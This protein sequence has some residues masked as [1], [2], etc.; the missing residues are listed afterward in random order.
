MTTI[1]K[2]E[3]ELDLDSGQFTGKMTQAGQVV[4]V[5][6]K[7]VNQV[8]QSVHRAEQRITGLT[9]RVR[10]LFVILGQA[11]AAMHTLWSVTGSWAS[12]I[13]KAAAELE[14]LQKL[15]EG[16]SRSTDATQRR[17]EGMA[18]LKFNLDLAKN[19]P[20]EVEQ[21]TNAFVK[22]KSAGIDPTAG[23]LQGL[24]DAVAHFGGNGQVLNRASVAIQQMA[25]KGVI[26]MEELRQQLGEAIP[27]AMEMMARGAGVSVAELVK[28]ISTGRVEAKS[29]LAIMFREFD[30]EFKGS[31]KGMMNTWQGLIAQLRTEFMVFSKE[32]GDAG[33]MDALKG[34]V[35][36]LIALTKDPQF[37]H[38]AVD[39]GKGL[40]GAVTGI[41]DLV[42]WAVK[43]RNELELIAAAWIGI[44]LGQFANTALQGLG[45]VLMQLGSLRANLASTVAAMGAAR[46]AS[47][48]MAAAIGAAAGPI[49][50]AITA[51]T[52]LGAVIWDMKQQTEA[53][54]KT[55]RDFLDD[56]AKGSAGSFE[57]LTELQSRSAKLQE[58]YAAY[59][60][61]DRSTV[62]HRRDD[63]NSFI[64]NELGLEF[65]EKDIKGSVEKAQKVVSDAMR[66]WREN[67]MRSNLKVGTEA[68]T[69]QLSAAGE[70]ALRTLRGQMV[71]FQRQLTEA[72]GSKTAGG[73]KVLAARADAI[74]AAYA[75]VVD[76][77]K[78]IETAE[79]AA[80]DRNKAR[81]GDIAKEYEERWVKAKEAVQKAIETRDQLLADQ[82]GLKL[83]NLPNQ[84]DKQ[85]ADQA[86]N[87]LA[88]LKGNVAELQAKLAGTN[89]EMDEF[90]A[91]LAGGATAL[92][93]LKP[94]Q[95]KEAEQLLKTY[96]D[97]KEQLKEQ[98]KAKE[99]A[100]QAD[101]FLSQKKEALLSDLQAEKDLLA[102]GGYEMA[103]NGLVRLNR[104]LARQAEALRAA[105][106]DMDA[107]NKEADELR[108]IQSSIDLSRFEQETRQLRNQLQLDMAPNEHARNQI[109]LEREIAQIR[110]RVQAEIDA[111]ADRVQAEALALDRIQA[112][113]DQFHYHDRSA[114]QRMLDDWKDATD[115]LES[116]SANVF[117]S[118]SGSIA[119]LVV[120]GKANFKDLSKM[121]IKELIKIAI[122]AMITRIAMS[123]MGGSTAPT[124]NVSGMAYTGANAAFAKGGV[125][126]SGGP[127]PLRAYANGGIAK[128]P[129]LAL[130]GEGSR[131]EAYVPLPDG[132]SIPVTMSGASQN[133][134]V[135]IINETGNKVEGEQKGSRFDGST[136]ILDVVLKAVNKPGSFRDGMK[137]ALTR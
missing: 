41:I 1:S 71:D 102:S 34:G 113:R 83:L 72:G 120:D 100:A 8:A 48:G 4:Q 89:S 5:F 22:L 36:E 80:F 14:R 79:Q 60:R 77:L 97:L 31:S 25:G 15:M 39:L 13:V 86:T 29:A 66:K 96:H 38:F 18:S 65:D 40:G 20:F 46:V 127:M 131:P 106:G 126:T 47:G 44:K 124:A 130:F 73:K 35:R 95:V 37:R 62:L 55:Y 32:V 121:I 51:L 115:E 112:L 33:F 84:K 81:G 91:K 63:L 87:W 133:V 42:K 119:D 69:S 135:N 45:A 123:F 118:M 85:A 17:L 24:V 3:V 109:G 12:A 134:T 6:G 78:K 107:F 56:L 67:T 53:A 104:E 90:E 108:R 11:R 43:F 132:R 98:T 122:Q 23:S 7:N 76:E 110:A 30:L 114:L 129:Q 99:A 9:A 57:G 93:G 92:K 49:G 59:R 16:L 105:K 111:G 88:S 26:S 52:A 50:I 128:S 116:W 61:A 101:A 103:S 68:L 28:A 21:I 10:D 64:K 125:M 70:D 94:A 82:K 137:S 19:A 117:S 27:S 58:L 136:L 74:T 2:L 75:Q 54:R